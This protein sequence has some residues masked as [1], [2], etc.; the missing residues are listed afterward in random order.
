MFPWALYGPTGSHLPNQL[1]AVS[2]ASENHLPHF[3]PCLAYSTKHFLAI[4]LR[5]GGREP[6]GS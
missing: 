6:P 1:P 3:H 2:N 5:F 4:R